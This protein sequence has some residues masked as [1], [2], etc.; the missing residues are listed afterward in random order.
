MLIDVLG[1]D[2]GGYVP[3]MKAAVRAVSDAEATLEVLLCQIVRI[4]R[5]GEP[6]RCPSAPA[7]SSPSAT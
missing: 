7:P 6:V 5:G 2:H 3:R 1:A 4:V